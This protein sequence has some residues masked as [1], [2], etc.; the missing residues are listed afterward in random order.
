M[1]YRFDGSYVLGEVSLGDEVSLWPTACVRGDFAPV[2]IGAKTNVQE[3]AVLHTELGIPLVIGSGVTI[4]HRAIVHGCTIEDEV[5]IGMGA[6]IMNGV[7]IGKHSI[8]GAGA[9]VLE[10]MDI[11]E[12]SLVVGAPAKIIRQTSA[13]QVQA[14]KTSVV[15]Y[16]GLARRGLG[17]E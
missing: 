9:L 10:N 15:E 17:C 2:T 12:N 5:L 8:I 14:I 7:H 4:G 6:I 11:P 1:I 16:I 3:G 13:E